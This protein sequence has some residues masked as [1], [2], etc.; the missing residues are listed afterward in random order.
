[1]AVSG[2]NRTP[3]RVLT[4]FFVVV[5]ALAL[6][7]GGLNVWGS[8]QPHPRLGL[9]LEGGTQLVLTPRLTGNETVTTEQITQARNIISQRVDAQGVAGAEVTTQGGRNIV[10]SMPGVPDRQTE[11]AIRR[12]S[13]MQFRPVL[14]AGPGSPQPTPT[15][16]SGGNGSGSGSATSTPGGS[17]SPSATSPSG[18]RTSPASTS[19]KAADSATSTGTST[20]KSGLPGALTTRGPAASTSSGSATG[21]STAP[22]TASPA[23]SSTSSGGSSATGGASGSASPAATPAASPTGPTDPSWITPAVAKRFQ[24]LD[25]NKPGVLDTV[26]DNPK[27]PLVTCSTDGTEKFVLGP[28]VVRGDQIADATAGYQTGQTGQPTNTVEI[29]LTFTGDAKQAYFDISKKMVT[30]PS[31]RNRLASTLDS[32]VIVAPQFNEAIPGGTASITGGFTIEEA[33]SLAN[34]L[35]FGALP[36]SFDLQT[37]DQISPTLGEEQLQLGLL[38]GVI[39]LLL[40]VVYSLFQYRALGLVTVGSLVMAAVISYLAITLLGW[41]YNY[42]LDMAGVTGLIVAIGITADSFIVYFERVRD[43]VRSGRTLRTA[44]DTGWARARRTILAADGVSFLAAAVLY[45]LASSNVRGFAFTLGLT[46]L[47]D[48]FIV[49]AFTH[50]ILTVLSTTRFFG[51]G[52]PWS[53]LDPDRLGSTAAR[54]TGRGRVA[55]SPRG[56]HPRAARAGGAAPPGR[57]GRGRT[58]EGSA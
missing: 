52:H 17:Q 51:G 37:R 5:A 26:D 18:S 23:A 54:A 22:S 44:V 34:Q 57:A 21:S 11:E 50:P 45:V 49:F 7:L 32:K 47:I 6:V 31:P 41:G 19:S 14:A 16:T 20:Q 4:G 13:Q 25:C 39:G 56:V 40:V 58:S 53:G 36:L 35:K 15:S 1:M 27:K 30:L 55:P 48:V 12:S 24:Q 43:E 42:R 46:T 3:V 33:R 38:A 10:V 29:R 2:R 28:V 9:D 8:A